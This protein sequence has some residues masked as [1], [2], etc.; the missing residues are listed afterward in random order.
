M[1]YGRTTTDGIVRFWHANRGWGVI[2]APETPGGCW[3]HYTHI[4]ADA[5][6]AA[7]GFRA[8]SGSQPMEFTREI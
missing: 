6:T 1:T 3:A 7:G 8:L 5:D 2:D 4:Q